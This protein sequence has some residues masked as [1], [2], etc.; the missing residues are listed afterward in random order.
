MRDDHVMQTRSEQIHDRSR[1]DTDEEDHHRQRDQREGLQRRRVGQPRST[2]Y[3]A[4]QRTSAAASRAGSLPSARRR[5]PRESSG[6]AA[7]R[8]SPV[9]TDTP[10]RS[11]SGLAGRARRNRRSR[12]ATSAWAYACRCRR[13]RQCRGYAPCRRARRRQKKSMPV[14]V[15]WVNICSAAPVSAASRKSEVRGARVPRQRLRRGSRS[16]DAEQHVAHVADAGVGDHL[17]HVL[18][19]HR[20]A[21]APQ[22]VDRGEDAEQWSRTPVAPIGTKPRQMRIRP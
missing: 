12:R 10:R 7:A 9:K 16:R 2:S 4:A 15:P 1:E 11:R 20:G 17:L 22:D 19:H 13:R 18:L 14:I 3:S 6:S 5:T 21:R 8:R